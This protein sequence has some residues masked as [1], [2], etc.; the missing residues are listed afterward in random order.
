[1]LSGL[2]NSVCFLGRPEVPKGPVSSKMAEGLWGRSG[3]SVGPEVPG[4]SHI[5]GP[6]EAEGNKPYEQGGIDL[7]ATLPGFNQE[8]EAAVVISDDD[9]TSFPAD[10]PQAISTLKI[11]LAWGQKQPLED[12]SPRSSPPKKQATEEKEESPPPR[13]AVLPRGVSEEDILPKRYEI[14]TSGYDWVQSVRGSLLGLEAGTSPSRRDID[15][16]SHFVPRAAAS[17]SDLPEVITEHWLPILRRE[18]LLMEC[19]S[20]QFTAPV[21]WVPLYTHEGLQKYLPAALSSFP[22]QGAPSLIA[23]APP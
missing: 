11:E 9:E 14:F 16:L 6:M 8:D 23:I 22:S 2:V 5:D 3:V 13:E 17:E 7:D 1:M 19:P 10:M 15:N 18:G 4:P 12:R 21:D 20:D